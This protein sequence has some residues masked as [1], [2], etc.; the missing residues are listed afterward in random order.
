MQTNKKI[1]I[2]KDE[3]VPTAQ[4]MREAGHVLVMIHGH[5]DKDGQPVISYHYD[6]GPET[7]GYEVVGEE[8]VPSI[9]PIYDAAAEWPERE[10][11]E[12]L[13]FT[14]TGL[15]TSERLFLPDNMLDGK[16]Q[17]IVTPINVLKEKNGL[18]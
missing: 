6:N 8:E 18:L 17:I 11:N 14:F 5:R 7:V 9:A 4:A 1:S 16:G 2:T 12:L 3:I 10:L 13:G 15:D